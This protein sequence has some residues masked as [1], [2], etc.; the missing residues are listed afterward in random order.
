MLIA[1][2]APTSEAF[3]THNRHRLPKVFK[4]LM[5]AS[6]LR[7][8]CDGD[9]L[10]SEYS[11]PP[12]RDPQKPFPSNLSH[13]RKFPSSANKIL[14]IMRMSFNQQSVC[15]TCGLLYIFKPYSRLQVAS[16]K[17]CDFAREYQHHSKRI[18]KAS[19]RIIRYISRFLAF[20]FMQAYQNI[21]F[22]LRALSQAWLSATLML[23]SSIRYEEYTKRWSIPCA[24]P[25]PKW[26][27]LYL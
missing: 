25:M 1:P 27:T 10:N 14:N 6:G 23:L 26:R 2:R 5:P 3:Y 18:L 16:K 9:G 7:S 13:R 17:I 15:F 22:L 21:P 19:K 24:M 8:F 4:N 12:Q 11:P 20:L